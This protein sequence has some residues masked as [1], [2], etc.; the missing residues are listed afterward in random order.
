[1]LQD[2]GQAWRLTDPSSRRAQRGDCSSPRFLLPSRRL[3]PE[4]LAPSAAPCLT[5]GICGSRP[6]SLRP[7]PGPEAA[8]SPGGSGGATPLP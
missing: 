5:E 1:M 4:P 3:D 8:A 2:F 6:G 7:C